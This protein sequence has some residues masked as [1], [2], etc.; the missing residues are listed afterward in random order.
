MLQ[1]T[2]WAFF[3]EETQRALLNDAFTISLES[4]RMGYRLI[5]EKRITIPSPHQLIS[6]AVTF[7]TIQMPPNGEPIIL[8]ADRQTT[9]GY[10]KI[11][12]VITA[13]L[14][15]LAQLPPQTRITFEMVTMYEAENAARR[16]HQQLQAVSW[17]CQ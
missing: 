13:D 7:G 9:G 12:Q 6:E 3:D 16:L 15:R 8:M 2:E 14:H 5:P 17:L 11:G 4:D 1:G 10:P